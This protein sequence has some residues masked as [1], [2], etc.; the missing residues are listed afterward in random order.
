MIT[1]IPIAKNVRLPV[2]IVLQ[3]QYVLLV[4]LRI[5]MKITDALVKPGITRILMVI[6]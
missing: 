2:K 1:V 6:A 3:L 4:F 5:E